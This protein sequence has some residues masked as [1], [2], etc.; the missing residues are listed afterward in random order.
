MSVCVSV[1]VCVPVCLCVCVPVCLCVCV[2][3]FLCVC[4]SVC[5]TFGHLQAPTLTAEEG[6]AAQA[7]GA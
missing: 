6:E 7:G 2:S 4:V 5:V 1:F 3:V